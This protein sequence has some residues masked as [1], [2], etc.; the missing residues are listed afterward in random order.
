VEKAQIR[1]DRNLVLARLDGDQKASI[2]VWI[3]IK[4]CDGGLAG[5]RNRQD[6]FISKIIT[7]NSI[8]CTCNVGKDST[9]NVGKDS[10]CD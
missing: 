6:I 10:A 7:E 2:H 1:A 9:C 5:R 3:K 4:F 8:S